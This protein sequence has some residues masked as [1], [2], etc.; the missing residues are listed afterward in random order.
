MAKRTSKT[1]EA[2]KEQFKAIVDELKANKIQA[3]DDSVKLQTVL[4]SMAEQTKLL[5]ASIDKM[6]VAKPK[7]VKKGFKGWV[8]DRMDKPKVSKPE[9]TGGFGE[10]SGKFLKENKGL[11]MG[12]AAAAFLMNPK[13]ALDVVTK[14]VSVGGNLASIVDK[15]GK[16]DFDGTIS[17]IGKAFSDNPV[18]MTGLAAF[19][20]YKG[21][22]LIKGIAGVGG[23]AVRGVAGAVGSAKTALQNRTMGGIK[24]GARTAY[25]KTYSETFK[26]SVGTFDEKKKKALEAAEQAK[27]SYINNLRTAAKAREA[28]ALSGLGALGES[29][30]GVAATGGAKV[31]SAVPTNI[32][33]PVGA[34]LNTVKEVGSTGLAKAASLA[35]SSVVTA[36]KGVGAVAGGLMTKITGVLAPLATLPGV[37]T[38]LKAIPGLGLLLSVGSAAMRVSDGDY[39]GAAIELASGVAG[40]FPGIGTA[41]ALGLQGVNFARDKAAE[42]AEKKMQEEGANPVDKNKLIP[43]NKPDAIPPKVL[44]TTTPTGLNAGTKK[45]KNAGM[46]IDYG[47]S[48]KTGGTKSWRNNNPGNIRAGDFATS[49]G[50]IGKDKDGFAVFPDEQ[51]GDKAREKLLFEGKNY[52][53]LSVSAAISRYAPPS[54]NNTG[55]YIADVSKAMGIDANTKMSDLTPEQRKTM[56]TAMKKKEGYEAGLVTAKEGGTKITPTMAKGPDNSN[57]K[58]A[59]ADKPKSETATLQTD[60]NKAKA[61]TSSSPKT[62]VVSGGGGGGSS[63]SSNVT[64]NVVTNINRPDWTAKDMTSSFSFAI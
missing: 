43:G 37:K 46:S 49:Q 7:D 61:E 16:S 29:A 40:L 28:G 64:N 11:L 9:K 57:A 63:N 2:D 56:M 27:K 32:V 53:D 47:D 6:S 62:V 45:L 26:T 4:E 34:A 3:S 17:A 31:A 30:K 55:A 54:E 12:G 51:T 19:A 25:S 5:I 21:A 33:S 60:L 15:I 48:V 59:A 23:A 52:K 39:I 8:Q 58:V 42:N 24:E 44:S 1:T 38:F 22:K 18:I 10:T 36:V 41:A 13:L 20:G 14:L 35:P 50:A